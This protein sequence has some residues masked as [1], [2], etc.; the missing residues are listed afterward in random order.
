VKKRAAELRAK[1]SISRVQFDLRRRLR[2]AS[3]GGYFEQSAGRAPQKRSKSYARKETTTMCAAASACQGSP[4][5][6]PAQILRKQKH[7]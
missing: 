7:K 4:G 1:I 6:G 5:G 3:S 2:M